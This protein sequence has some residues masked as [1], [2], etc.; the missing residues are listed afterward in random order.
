MAEENKDR[1]RQKWEEIKHILIGRKADREKR[2]KKFTDR[3]RERN[4]VD[5]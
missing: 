5:T 2:H 1:N 3:H 4:E